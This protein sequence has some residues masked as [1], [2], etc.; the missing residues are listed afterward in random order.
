MHRLEAVARL[1]PHAAALRALGAT[2]LFLFGS[3]A[4]NEA[5]PTSDIDLFVD[6]DPARKFSLADLAGIK[7]FLEQRLGARIDLTTRDS[8]H[9]TLRDEI[10]R[11]AVRIF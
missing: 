8:L 6:Y 3:S 1:S 9:P 11:S 7:L 4:R 5:A 10:E 2:A